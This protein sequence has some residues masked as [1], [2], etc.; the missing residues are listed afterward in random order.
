MPTRQILALARKGLRLDLRTTLCEA[1][2][3]GRPA[4]RL[5]VALEGEG[6]DERVQLLTL[7]VEPLRERGEEEPLYLV[8]FADEGQALSQDE[9][10]ALAHSQG[11]RATLWLE[12]ELRETRERLQSLI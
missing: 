12:G 1:V 11:E 4:A 7:T 5:G 8:L 2:E 9:A 10:Q 6:E 3:T